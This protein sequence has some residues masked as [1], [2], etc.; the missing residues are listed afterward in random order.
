MPGHG[1]EQHAAGGEDAVER[2]E[3]GANVVDELERL[4]DDRAVER[5]V[6]DVRRVREV[7]DD[8]RLG[9]AFASPSGCRCARHRFRT[10]TCSPAPRSRAR[11]RG[12]RRRASRRTPRRR[13]GRSACRA[14][15]PSSGRSASHDAGHRATEG[16]GAATRRTWRARGGAACGRPAGRSGGCSRDDRRARARSYGVVAASQPAPSRGKRIVVVSPHLDDGVLSLGASMASW[17]RHGAAVELLTVLACDPASKAPAGGWDSRGGFATEGESALARREED[18]QA[19]AVLGAYAGVAALRERGLRA[20]WRRDRGARCRPARA[21]GRRQRPRPGLPSQPPRSRL[22]RG[23]PRRRPRPVACRPLRGA[24]VHTSRGVPI[25]RAPA[26]RGM[27][28]RLDDRIAKWRAIRCYAS[29]LPLLA[30]RRS[31]RRGAHRYAATPEWIA[32]G[33]DYPSTS[34]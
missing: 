25:R 13:R 27:P 14:R 18:R 16:V 4:G 31:L 8:R 12:C 32:W 22:A 29:Q 6:R 3:R 34:A 9:V 23:A 15:S 17:A 30:M 19:C 7:A 28:A 24:A 2:R 11:G 20:P 26:S 10:A 5:L 21:R 33:P 1:R